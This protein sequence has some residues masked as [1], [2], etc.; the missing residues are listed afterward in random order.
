[1]F[2]QYDVIISVIILILVTVSFFSGGIRSILGMIKWYGAAFL[3]V[4]FYPYTKQIVEQ[5]LQPSDVI[6]GV[7]VVV[8]YIVAVILLA[9]IN[10]ILIAAMGDTV[11]G[12]FD[13]FIGAIVGFTIGYIIAATM[14]FA[15][16]ISLKQDQ[17]AWFKNGKLYE[18]T[19]FGSDILRSY[20]KDVV[21]EIEDDIGVETNIDQDVPERE[22]IIQ[23]GLIDLKESVSDA[24]NSD[25]VKEFSLPPSEIRRRARELKEEGY[26]ADEI[27][28][29]IRKESN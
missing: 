13:K 20:L 14:H 4:A 12:F 21:D 1:M 19:K 11:G 18:F 28:E 5:V 9:I 27:K 29:I 15:L 10:R 7:A 2:T 22:D 23:D 3:T 24:I 8:V 6:N 16:E 26:N 17:P 25:A